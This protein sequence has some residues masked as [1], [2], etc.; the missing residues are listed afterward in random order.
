MKNIVNTGF[1]ESGGGGKPS[2]NAFLGRFIK[3]YFESIQKKCCKG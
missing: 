1:A 3:K 2:S